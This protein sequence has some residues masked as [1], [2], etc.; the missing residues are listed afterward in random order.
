MER[1][2]QFSLPFLAAC[3]IGLIVWSVISE[4]RA[5]REEARRAK[6]EAAAAR[7]QGRRR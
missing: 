3:I 4:R 2:G 6:A 1:L 5:T 7:D